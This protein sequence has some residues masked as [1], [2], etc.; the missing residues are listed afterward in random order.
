MTEDF[1]IPLIRLLAERHGQREIAQELNQRELFRPDGEKW[2]QAAVSRFM[3][4]HSI[5]P[6]FTFKV[7]PS[8]VK[9]ENY[10]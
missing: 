3:R 10:S 8:Y 9:E 4:S 7:F 1:L 6:K 5:T 2:N